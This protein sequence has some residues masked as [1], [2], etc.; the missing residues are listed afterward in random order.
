MVRLSIFSLFFVPSAAQTAGDEATVAADEVVPPCR[1]FSTDCSLCYAAQNSAYPGNG[2]H[3]CLVTR[4]GDGR[5]EFVCS[6]SD[7]QQYSL[8]FGSVES[9]D[10]GVNVSA[11]TVAKQCE[12]WLPEDD[13]VLGPVVDT[14]IIVVQQPNNVQIDAE[15]DKQTMYIIIG[16]VSFCLTLLTFVFFWSSRRRRRGRIAS[17]AQDGGECDVSKMK[18]KKAL[19][20]F[21]NGVDKN[22]KSME[23]DIIMQLRSKAIQKAQLQAA[24]EQAGRYI[25]ASELA[26]AIDIDEEL[27]DLAKNKEIFLTINGKQA[28]LRCGQFLNKMA[29]FPKMKI[30]LTGDWSNDGCL[31]KKLPVPEAAKDNIVELLSWPD[32]KRV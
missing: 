2:C 6:D 18:D 22:F 28:I 7:C 14:T 10:L 8:T 21:W 25:H 27:A 5:K 32:K 13:T 1:D 29:E 17:A 23:H 26:P 24:M 19:G 31:N 3:F 11:E 20:A 15:K 30:R 9:G 12:N 16:S 4:E